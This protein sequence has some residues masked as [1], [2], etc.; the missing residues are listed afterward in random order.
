MGE[1]ERKKKRSKLG[2]KR[3]GEDE[4]ESGRERAGGVW[5][6]CTAGSNQQKC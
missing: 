5:G 6:G 4:E 1:R 3:E 2:E